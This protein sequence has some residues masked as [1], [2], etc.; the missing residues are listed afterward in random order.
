MERI[1][2]CFPCYGIEREMVQDNYWYLEDVE[3]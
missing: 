1:C 2:V 3:V